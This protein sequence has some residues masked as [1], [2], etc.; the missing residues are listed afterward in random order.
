MENL[1]YGVIGNCRTAALVSKRG[2]IDWFCL[3][4]FD[5]PSIF[6]KLLDEEKGGSFHFEVSDDYTIT[7]NYHG[8]TNILL[9]RFES[10]EHGFIVFDYMPRYHTV[11]HRHYMPPEIHRYIR[12]IKGQPTV[13]VIYDPK[14]NYAREEVQHEI[15]SNYIRTHS[16]EDSEDKMYLYT[17]MDREKVLQRE[18]I[19]LEDHH[20]FLLS[21]NQKLVT[22]DINRIL[23]EYERTK[24]YWLNFVNR[25]RDYLEYNDMIKRSLLVLKLLSYQDSGAMLAAA[26]TSLPESI[27]ETRN[28][29]YRFCWLRDAS[30]SID[31]LLFM[32]QRTAA[33][34]FIGFVK[35]ILKSSREET[36]QIMYGIRGERDLVEEVLP[37][38][39]GYENSSPVRIGN[40]AYYQEQNDSIG[41]LLD[42]IYKYYLYFPGT[43]DEVEEIWEIIKNL[44]RQVLADWRK[45]DRSIWEY[46]TKKM[47][48]VFSKVMSW[49]AVDRASLI[50][51]LLHRDYYAEKWRLEANAIKEEVHEKGWN[52]ELQCFTQAYENTDYDSSL[53][54]MQFYDFI[55][56]DDERYV[57]T[58]KATKENLYHE[59]LMYRYKA[60]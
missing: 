21:Y 51:E 39:S 10:P 60:E 13:K 48:F 34:R 26:T 7:Q 45:P 44:V 19:M 16:V 55:E 14:I 12:V 33:E 17:S 40:A 24:V 31:T 52:E 20:F 28:W 58:V 42:V 57:K 49:V 23:L 8:H 50:A 59:G 53:L 4:D 9:T 22:V 47:H 43:L 2:S 46:R 41:Y 56:A 25:S 38:L 30:M 36:I 29:D 15:V 18:E 1:D 54:L 27:G 11:E 5:S 35:R 32:K 3:P 37:H 6:A